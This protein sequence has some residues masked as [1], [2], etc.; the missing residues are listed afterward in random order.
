MRKTGYTIAKHLSH[1][2]LAAALLT[3]SLAAALEFDGMTLPVVPNEHDGCES[4]VW[5]CVN[6]NEDTLGYDG[7]DIDVVETATIDQET[8]NPLCNLTFEVLFKGASFLN[9][10]GW[11]E[12]QRDIDGYPVRPDPSEMHVMLGCDTPLGE[13]VNLPAPEGVTEIGFFLANNENG[14][15][16]TNADGTLQETQENLFFSERELNDDDGRVH[17]LIW[18]SRANPTAF[19]FGWEDQHGG[20]DNDFEDLLTFVTGIQCAGGGELC[21]TGDPGICGQGVQQCRDGVLTCVPLQEPGEESCNAVDDDCD[22]EVDDGDLCEADMVCHQGMCQ[23]RC[24]GGEFRCSPPL[25]CDTSGVCVEAECLDVACDSGEVCR[26]GECV[27][28][29]DGVECPYGR[30]CRAGVCVD[31]CAGVECDDGFT[32]TVAFPEEMNGAPVGLCSSCGCS[33]CEGGFSCESNICIEDA[34]VDMSCAGGFRC[35]AGECVDNCAGAVCPT[36][37]K[38]AAG[39]CVTDPDYDPNGE[40][41]EGSGGGSSN[42]NTTGIPSNG[43]SGVNSLGMTSSSNGQGGTDTTSGPLEGQS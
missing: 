37:M 6:E 13:T 27:G 29:C 38:C 43:I 33:G 19:Y 2:V 42:T 30:A 40:G 7:D 20:G 39:E 14:P 32:C 12:V 18:Q 26:G 3:P 36:G 15:C 21:E 35:E 41:G 17:L 25:V 10:F 1:G 22:G 31:V 8:F 28:A 34:C 23:P 9:V 5:Y 11:Y 24:G 16:V 4:D